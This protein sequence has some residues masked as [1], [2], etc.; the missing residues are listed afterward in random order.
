MNQLETWMMLAHGP[1]WIGNDGGTP[2]YQ[3]ALSQRAI[4]KA[5]TLMDRYGRRS[6]SV[7][8]D[9]LQRKITYLIETQSRAAA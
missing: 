9:D 7:K 5:L 1:V 6:K 2:V 4:L 8:L 3:T